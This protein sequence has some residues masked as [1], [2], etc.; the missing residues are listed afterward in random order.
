[1]ECEAVQTCTS[2]MREMHWQ[3]NYAPFFVLPKTG[4][5]YCCSEKPRLSSRGSAL[6]RTPT[7]RQILACP[8]LAALSRCCPWHKLIVKHLL[9]TFLL[10]CFF[11][12]PELQPVTP[13][14]I[15]EASSVQR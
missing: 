10:A 11:W 2:A 12:R 1:M 15:A 3:C 6:A 4:L 13:R 9:R 14:E 7:W 8:V 5:V